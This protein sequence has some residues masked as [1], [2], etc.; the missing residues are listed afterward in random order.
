MEQAV[1]LFGGFTAVAIVGGII[2]IIYLLHDNK[3][4]ETKH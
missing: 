1:L 4:R 3:K 2:G